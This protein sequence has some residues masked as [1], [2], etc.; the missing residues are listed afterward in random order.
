MCYFKKKSNIFENRRFISRVPKPLI[1]VTNL[2][3]FISSVVLLPSSDLYYSNQTQQNSLAWLIPPKKIYSTT[4]TALCAIKVH[5]CR[6]VIALGW[7]I[8]LSFFFLLTWCCCRLATEC[9][10][11]TQWSHLPANLAFTQLTFLNCKETEGGGR[12]RGWGEGG[13]SEEPPLKSCKTTTRRKL[14]AL[15]GTPARGGRAA[16]L[17]I[18]C[19]SSEIRFVTSVA[20]DELTIPAAWETSVAQTGSDLNYLGNDTRWISATLWGVFFFCDAPLRWQNVNI[21]SLRN[22]GVYLFIYLV[23]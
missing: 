20:S 6:W 2:Q 19:C 5:M 3:Q 10:P 12:R 9:V 18:W 23:S 1:G 17:S 14:A 13:V 15:P 22:R 16:P 4:H 8:C 7:L 11:P 21:S